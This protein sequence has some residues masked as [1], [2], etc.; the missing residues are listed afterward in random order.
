VKLTNRCWPKLALR[1][2]PQIEC[3]A[4]G[5]NTFLECKWSFRL[6]RHSH[7]SQTYCTSQYFLTSVNLF[8]FQIQLRHK[9]AQL[10]AG[11][12]AVK[13]C[14]DVVNVITSNFLQFSVSFILMILIKNG[15]IQDQ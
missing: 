1:V 4:T 8:S 14:P 7:M 2:P 15:E 10:L 3:F 11:T 12:L 9:I 5:V 6:H 13:L